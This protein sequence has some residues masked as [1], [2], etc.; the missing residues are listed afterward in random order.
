MILAALILNVLFAGL[1]VGGMLAL[2]GW[3]IATDAARRPREARIQ[4]SPRVQPVR[5][6]GARADLATR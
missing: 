4:R 6:R 3:A 1:V 5:W 2:H